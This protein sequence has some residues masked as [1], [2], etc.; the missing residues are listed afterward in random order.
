MKVVKTVSKTDNEEITQEFKVF[1]PR[2]YDKL[3]WFVTIVL[4]AFSALYL[5][6]AAQWDLPSPE[7]VVATI[8]GITAFLGVCLGISSQR[9]KNSDA[10]YDGKAIVT[11]D[12]GGLA[13]VRLELDG[14]P[15]ELVDKETV[16]FRIQKRAA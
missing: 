6:L 15:E 1:S 7:K 11:H 12:E 9:Y 14:D 2:F 13:A 5:T 16:A 4:P 10:P 8:T 3:K